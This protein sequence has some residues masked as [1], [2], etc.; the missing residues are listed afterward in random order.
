MRGCVPKKLLVYASRFS[1]YFEDAAGNG[2]SVGET[3][4]SWPGLIAAKDRE[5]DR[6]NAIYHRL[7]DNAGVRLFKGR[8]RLV[9]RHTVEVGDRKSTR[10]NSS[11]VA[12]S[13]AVFCSKKKKKID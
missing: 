5:I 1:E 11:H 13:Y 9:D 8:G 7:L 6:L 3:G 2:W 4:F 12:I 10:L